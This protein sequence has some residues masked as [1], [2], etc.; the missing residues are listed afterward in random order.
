MPNLFK[1]Y[2]K[3]VKYF[4]RGIIIMCPVD[5]YSIITLHKGHLTMY[6]PS[7]KQELCQDKELLKYPWNKCVIAF[8]Y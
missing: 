4:W 1:Y 3:F 7:T 2:E 5:T 6:L 8:N